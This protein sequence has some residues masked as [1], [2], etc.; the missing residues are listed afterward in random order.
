MSS[1]IAATRNRR[2][3]GKPPEKQKTNEKFPNKPMV[4]LKKR[5][6][7]KLDSIEREDETGRDE[8][9]GEEAEGLTPELPFM[10]IGGLPEISRRKE[11]DVDRT[12]GLGFSN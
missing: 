8:V 1:M 12:K 5:Q 4:V 3:V 2:V 11:P 6:G 9:P 7:I 10:E